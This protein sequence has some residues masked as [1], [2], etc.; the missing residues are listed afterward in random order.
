MSRHCPAC[1]LTFA[2]HYDIESH[3]CETDRLHELEQH[4]LRDKHGRMAADPALN[5][6]AAAACGIDASPPVVSSRA[7]VRNDGDAYHNPG[8]R[9]LTPGLADLSEPNYRAVD[10]HCKPYRAAI[11]IARR[12]YMQI[13][14]AIEH[15]LISSPARGTRRL[16]YRCVSSETSD[17]G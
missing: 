5:L 14:N 8:F 2:Y 16:K 13:L 9:R 3:S 17:T 4:T 15:L 7:P 1:S 6:D 10:A 11:P 12:L